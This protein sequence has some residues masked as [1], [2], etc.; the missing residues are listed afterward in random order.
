MDLEAVEAEEEEDIIALKESKK[1]FG[2][3]M[4]GS[5][6]IGSREIKGVLNVGEGHYV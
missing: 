3:A 4:E 5:V 6:S 1:R 2:R